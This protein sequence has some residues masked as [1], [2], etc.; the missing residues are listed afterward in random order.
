MTVP[1]N[2]HDQRVSQQDHYRTNI[3]QGQV[4]GCILAAWKY[5]WRVFSYSM[6]RSL[7]SGVCWLVY[8]CTSKSDRPASMFSSSHSRPG[9]KNMAKND[10][11]YIIF[12]IISRQ[13]DIT[14]MKEVRFLMIKQ[15]HSLWFLKLSR[16]D[17][18]FPYI[19]ITLFKWCANWYHTI[20]AV[21]DSCDAIRFI[22]IDLSSN[23]KYVHQ[24]TTAKNM[25]FPWDE[26]YVI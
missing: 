14:V 23:S 10:V 1:P 13:H 5:L 18:N 17:N 26:N 21:V 16:H 4:D 19:S 9:N 20:G 2:P 15:T 3:K 25:S 24:I 12:I 8:G 11:C 6:S 22:H 7:K